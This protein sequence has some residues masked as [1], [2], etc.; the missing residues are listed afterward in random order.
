MQ[1]V[2]HS[3]WFPVNFTTCQHLSLAN[4]ITYANLMALS[5]CSIDAGLFPLLLISVE[6][7]LL[8]QYTV[9]TLFTSTPNN[10][11]TFECAPRP[12]KLTAVG[13]GGLQ[14]ME[15]AKKGASRC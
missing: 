11:R 10:A 13:E 2:V 3:A 9:Y 8:T 1:S 5:K 12:S 14:A 4:E 7:S 6:C 15:Y